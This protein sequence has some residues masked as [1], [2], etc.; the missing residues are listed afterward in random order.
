MSATIA[1]TVPAELAPRRDSVDM[2]FE[3]PRIP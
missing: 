1:M 2:V 3:W